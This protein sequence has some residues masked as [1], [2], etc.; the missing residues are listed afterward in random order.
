MENQIKNQIQL[1]AV[2]PVNKY[3]QEINPNSGINDQDLI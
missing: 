3:K 1:P 2:I